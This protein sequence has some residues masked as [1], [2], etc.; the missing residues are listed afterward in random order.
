VAAIPDPAL[1]DVLDAATGRLAREVLPVFFV[2]VGSDGAVR[3]SNA[4][5]RRLLGRDPVGLPLP[6]LLVEAQRG[7]GVRQLCERSLI[8]HLDM[9]AGRP[10][11]V[12]VAA[13]PVGDGYAVVGAEDPTDLDLLGAEL[14]LS[15]QRLSVATR[16][17][18]R[19]NAGLS[20][21]AARS[22]GEAERALQASEARLR[23]IVDAYPGAL[24]LLDR[25]GRVQFANA[26]ASPAP[27][28]ASPLGRTLAEIFPGETAQF[29]PHLERALEGEGQRFEV[30]HDLGDGR[31]AWERVTYVPLRD[32]RGQVAQVMGAGEDVS[33]EK[34]REAEREEQLALRIQLAGVAAAVPGLVY[35]YRITPDGKTSMPFASPVVEELLG[36]PGAA[37]AESDEVLYARIPTE[38]AL[39]LAEGSRR[40][41]RDLQPWHLTFR[42]DHPTKG[43]RVLEGRAVPHRTPDGGVLS[44][45]FLMDVTEQQAAEQA[46]RASTAMAAARDLQLQT[47]VRTALDGYW[48]VDGEGRILEVNDAYCAMSG[49]T[50]G[51]LLFMRISD[52]EELESEEETLGHLRAVF[53]RGRG[54]FESRHRRKD[55]TPLDVEI[56]TARHGERLVTFLRDITER[57]RAEAAERRAHEEL[58]ALT[59]RLQDVRE[60]EKTRIARDLHDDLGQAL[61]GLQYDMRWLEDRVDALLPEA[62][63]GEVLDRLVSASG[64]ASAMTATLQRITRELRPVVLDRLGL[65]AALRQDLPAFEQRTGITVRARLEVS[66][67]LP[68]ELAT[69]LYRICQEALT[70][71]ARH[72]GAGSVEVELREEGGAVVL[73]VADDGVGL[74][75]PRAGARTSLG[76]L[77]MS[78]R[79]RALGGELFVRARAGGGTE[80]IAS[81]P[82]RTGEE[83][84]G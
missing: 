29:M 22:S 62:A 84:R 72:S 7:I 1:T 50:R 47:V 19:A 25:E 48:V 80:V 18:T 68:A 77:G 23:A 66:A 27:P 16:E 79:A 12:L 37:L 28:G 39:A 65:A 2:F 67:G 41:L 56:S 17:L 20:K 75:R 69:A 38:D 61:T 42:Y 74:G 53:E 34:R 36:F 6:A 51:E 11:S 35:Q 57:K 8:L 78:E 63:K 31:V 76:I 13:A 3:A 64:L 4:H 15:N 81:V 26:V 55:G 43:P 32:A 59:G 60:Q 10:R 52:L 33:E 46:L 40:S 70:N 21:E 82:R 54:R 14:V 44:N 5:T 73:T 24:V 49:Y 58:R 45:G 30:R 71:V 9:P 83:T